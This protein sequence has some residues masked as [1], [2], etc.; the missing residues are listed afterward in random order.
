[1]LQLIWSILIIYL[2]TILWIHIQLFAGPLRYLG[3]FLCARRRELC[4]ATS[5][6]AFLEESLFLLIEWVKLY[7]DWFVFVAE[8][9]AISYDKRIACCQI[10]RAS[11]PWMVHQPMGLVWPKLLWSSF[12]SELLKGPSRL[13]NCIH[14]LLIVLSSSELYIFV[15]AARN[16]FLTSGS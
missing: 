11:S 16:P 7:V 9:L 14:C 13:A 15:M 5:F 4:I 10:S 8:E 1:M 12:A 2:C 3:V 6:S